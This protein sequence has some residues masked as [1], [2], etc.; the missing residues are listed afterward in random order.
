MGNLG[1]NNELVSMTI[2]DNKESADRYERSAVFQDI[3]K[4]ATEVAP[5]LQW[6]MELDSPLTERVYSSGDLTVG[7]YA[8]VTGKSFDGGPSAPPGA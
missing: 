6:K 4:K 3:L 8:V 5:A 2:W 7:S 1:A